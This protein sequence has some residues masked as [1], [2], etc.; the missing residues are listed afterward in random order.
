[1]HSGFVVQA[2]LPG[3]GAEEVPKWKR[4]SHPLMM[5]APES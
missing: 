1:M 4:R 3:K 2:E 5:A